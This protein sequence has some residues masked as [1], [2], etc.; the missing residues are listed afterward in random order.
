MSMIAAPLASLIEQL[1]ADI[2]RRADVESAGWLGGDD[3]TRVSGDLTRQNH[4]L[5]I[6]AGKILC[7]RVTVTES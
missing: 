3:G 2:F 4:L 5:D 6:A 1:F 7:Q